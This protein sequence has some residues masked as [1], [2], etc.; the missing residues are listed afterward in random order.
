VKLLDANVL[1]HA[2][3]PDFPDHDRAKEWLEGAVSGVE[4]IGLAWLTIIAFLRI[5]TS[6]RGF[7]RPI[8]AAE[9]V[10]I[11]SSWLDRSNVRIIESGSAHWPI[12]A[13]LI[14]GSQASGNLAN[15][16]HLAALA[17][18]HGATL[19]THDRD[20]SRFPGLRLEDPLEE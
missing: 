16:A 4:P 19:A 15:D 11:V 10:R 12:L 2:Y 18:E 5:T 6:P 9:A 3:N 14:E 20:F 13:R 17:I 7:P 1:L 8:S